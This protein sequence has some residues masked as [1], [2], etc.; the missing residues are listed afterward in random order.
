MIRLRAGKCRA[1][2]GVPGRQLGHD[3]AGSS[4]GIGQRRVLR[5]VDGVRPGAEHRH[6][7]AFRLQG[8]PVRGRIDAPG[9]AADDDRARSGE[10]RGEFGGGFDRIGGGAP[11]ADQGD[12]RPVKSAAVS[13]HPQNDGRI[14]DEREQWR[15]PRAPQR[16]GVMA[17]RGGPVHRAGRVFAQPGE[18]RFRRRAAGGL[19][20]RGQRERGKVRR[21]GAIQVR[22]KEVRQR[23][24]CGPSARRR[25]QRH[26]AV[27]A[28]GLT[29]IGNGRGRSEKAKAGLA[30]DQ[31]TGGARPRPVI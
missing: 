9:E 4:N 11:R 24:G 16:N 1:R 26:R 21:G 7:G 6:R 27:R 20:C 10:R 12:R 14:L 17:L 2:G 29:R 18:D 5:R 31:R 22:P 13:E 19:D 25:G 23:G 15:V 30:T 8:A 3:R 28:C